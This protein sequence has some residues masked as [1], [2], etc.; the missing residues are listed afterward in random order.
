MHPPGKIGRLGELGELQVRLAHAQGLLNQ[1]SLNPVQDWAL[2]YWLYMDRR[3][4]LDDKASELEHQC[5]NLN[6]E[7]WGVLYRDQMLPGLVGPNNE[8]EIPVTDPRDLDAFYESLSRP[9]KMTGEDA[10]RFEGSPISA[11]QALNKGARR[12]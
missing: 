5:F 10:A 1:R 3:T 11:A 4:Q 7:R 9:R 8:P 6:P 12:V 2:K